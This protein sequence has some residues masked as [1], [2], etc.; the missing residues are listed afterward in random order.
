MQ[1]FHKLNVWQKSHQLTIAV[2]A[3][4][5]SFP[6]TEIYRRAA[7]SIPGNISEGCGRNGQAEL[8]RFLQIAMGSASEL[9]YHL[10][11]ARDLKYLDDKDYMAL[12]N[13]VCEVKRMLTVLI[14]KLKTEN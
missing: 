14:Q 11:L 4:T 2:Y 13:Q 5:K 6:S 7:S 10:L 3:A 1:D 8:G 12:D 9:E